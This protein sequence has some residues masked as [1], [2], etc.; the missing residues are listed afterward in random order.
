MLYAI[1]VV[2]HVLACMILIAV[3]L[4]QAGRGGGLSEAFGGDSSHTIF[5][6]KASVFL[7]RATV[8]AASVFIIT[9]LLLGILTSR[10]GRSLIDMRGVQGTLPSKIPYLPEKEESQATGENSQNK[11]IDTEELPIAKPEEPPK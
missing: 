4:L 2:V 6:T 9:C 10:R 5:G 7:S 3:I 8:V 11:V 1:V